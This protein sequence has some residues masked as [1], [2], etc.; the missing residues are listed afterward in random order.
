MKYNEL[1][2]LLKLSLLSNIFLQ[3]L[4]V[5]L[6]DWNRRGYRK[7]QEGRHVEKTIS[8]QKRATTEQPSMTRR[9]KNCD[10]G[11]PRTQTSASRW[12][13]STIYQICPHSVTIFCMQWQ[14][15]LEKNDESLRI[16][17]SSWIQS[18]D[19]DSENSAFWLQGIC[20]LERGS[21]RTWIPMCLTQKPLCRTSLLKT[22]KFTTKDWAISTP[23][24]WKP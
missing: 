19:D 17:D 12:E 10:P 18:R 16:I 20:N 13:V 1:K 6:R 22:K 2:T 15:R 24:D 3:W 5:I 23:V 7:R 14:E 21:A 11:V 9:L 8:W 4:M